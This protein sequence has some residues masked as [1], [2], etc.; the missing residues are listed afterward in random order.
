M[1][2]LWQV[3]GVLLMKENCSAKGATEGRACDAIR[4]G[5]GHPLNGMHS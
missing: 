3:D 4:S 2:G 1:G 5:I